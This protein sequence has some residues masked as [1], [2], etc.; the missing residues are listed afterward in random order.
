MLAYAETQTKEQLGHEKS[1]LEQ[2]LARL[3]STLDGEGE[4]EPH[5]ED[6]VAVERAKIAALV[7]VLQRRLHDVKAALEA[8]ERGLYGI[9]ERCGEA[10][11]PE[12]LA[13]KPDTTFCMPCQQEVETRRRGR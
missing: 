13:V 8:F 12:R 3:Q 1:R 5:E 11:S 4:S 7:D 9:C 2:E 6:M 10:I